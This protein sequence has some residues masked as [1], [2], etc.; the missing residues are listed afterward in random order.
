[1]ITCLCNFLVVSY[2]GGSSVPGN[3]PQ[4]NSNV[5]LSP[6]MAPIQLRQVLSALWA[7]E[8]GKA[9]KMAMNLMVLWVP[10]KKQSI[11]FFFFFN[12]CLFL[13]QTKRMNG[14]GSESGRHRIWSRLPALSCQH[15]A[16]HRARTHGLW[17]H[18]LSRS[19]MPNRLSHPGAP[20]LSFSNLLLGFKL[21]PRS[22]T[23]SPKGWRSLGVRGRQRVFEGQATQKFTHSHRINTRAKN[24]PDWG[25]CPWF[26]PITGASLSFLYLD[27]NTWRPRRGSGRKG[28]LQL[29]FY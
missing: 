12:I 22:L 19:Q 20:S 8:W 1:M 21:G 15:T 9:D 14:G 23:S 25:S 3:N 28:A 29:K 18:D 5:L 2:P 4:R 6:D 10:S 26:R 16:W 7:W 11:I 17:D 13:R 27:K 24:D